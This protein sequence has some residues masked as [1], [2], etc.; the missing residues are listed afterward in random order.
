M[1][2]CG[3]EKQ[4][5]GMILVLGKPAGKAEPLSQLHA[6]PWD[7]AGRACSFFAK[8]AA[9]FYANPL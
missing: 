5:G 6:F 1:T 9:P 7:S 8:R 4:R 3:G 2:L